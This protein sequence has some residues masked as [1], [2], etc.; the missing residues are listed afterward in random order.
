MFNLKKNNNKC[1]FSEKR[2]AVA[3]FLLNL[4]T[5]IIG[6]TIVDILNIT[7]T[8]FLKLFYDTF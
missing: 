6:Y 8:I 3:N 5:D 4:N 7:Y 2:L 1:D